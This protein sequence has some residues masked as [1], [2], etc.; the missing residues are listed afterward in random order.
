MLHLIQK[1][2]FFDCGCSSASGGRPSLSRVKTAMFSPQHH[3]QLCVVAHVCFPS[4]QEVE[5]GGSG[6]RGHPQLHSVFEAG[7]GYMRPCLIKQVL[8][9]NAKICNIQC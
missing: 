1:L 5:A 2:K 9:H 8:H 4:A 6:I 7:Q 3:I